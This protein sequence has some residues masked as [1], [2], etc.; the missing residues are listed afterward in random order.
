M[1]DVFV[2]RLMFRLYSVPR[3]PPAASPQQFFETRRLLAEHAA[4]SYPVKVRREGKAVEHINY[5]MISALSLDT[6]PGACRALK[7][8]LCGIYDRRPL[9]CR[10]VPIHYS[11]PV[12][13]A[14]ADLRAF[15]ATPG[16]G[17]DT[18]E[19]A[20]VVIE[21]GQVVDSDMRQARADAAV[22]AERD[23]PWRKAI[24]RRMKP[25]SSQTAGLP[26]LRDVEANASIGVTTASMRLGWQIA[27]DAGIIGP[28]EVERVV[29][30]QL[31]LIERELATG[32]CPES[33]RKTLLDMRAEYQR[34]A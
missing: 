3:L 6:S 34:P 9:T 31:A 15:V 4:H 2:F 11:R 20:P 17:C 29:A 13:T 22:V 8:Q 21:G 12:A 5:L 28:D 18:S 16:Y 25:A 24:V 23:R 10:A 26:S 19:T 27:S 14:D 33:V 30:A 7:S 1:A 32:L